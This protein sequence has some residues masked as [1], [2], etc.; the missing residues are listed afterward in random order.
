MA[1]SREART[2][3]DPP[4]R[5]FHWALAAFVVFSYVTGRLGGSWM[6]WHMRSGYTILVLLLFRIAWGFAGPEPSRFAVFL[7]AP[8]A[9]L[10]HARALAARAFVPASGHTPLG[11]WMVVAMLAALAAQAG[12]GLFSNDESSHQ[13][14]LAG[15]V[16]D[17]MVDRLSVLHGYG[18]WLIV[19][20]VAIH[21]AAVLYYRWG[22][23][24]DVLSP[25]IGGSGANAAM[26][27][28]AAAFLVAAAGIVYV[29]VV[30]YPS[31]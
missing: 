6:T 8:R 10:D 7:R 17:A 9:A 2:A 23:K 20:L 22:L 14:P 28:R 3:W 24:A 18:Q 15:E 26:L 11:G 25:M 13:G 16:S 31:R 1:A 21:V 5:L 30:V 12:S 29:L 27:A 4:T 19:T